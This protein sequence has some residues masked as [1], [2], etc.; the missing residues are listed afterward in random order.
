[1]TCHTEIVLTHHPY[2]SVGRHGNARDTL[3]W[4][5]EWPF[6]DQSDFLISGHA[7]LAKDFGKVG[8]TQILVSGAGADIEADNDG[9]LLIIEL[10]LNN[11]SL[12]Y[13]FKKAKKISPE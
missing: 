12:S 11:R 3:K 9:G 13:Q 1:M 8:K 5:Y 10:N 4:L 2:L 6:I 7:H